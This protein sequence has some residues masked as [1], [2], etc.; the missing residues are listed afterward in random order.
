MVKNIA[1]AIIG[2]FLISASYN[3]A[4]ANT[5]DETY[6][7]LTNISIENLKKNLETMTF[8]NLYL[9][10]IFDNRLI[11]K[12]IDECCYLDFM[13]GFN[14]YVFPKKISKMCR[15]KN[16]S[17]SDYFEAMYQRKEFEIGEDMRNALL[18]LAYKACPK[19]K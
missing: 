1:A 10:G 6:K 3:L 12:D 8:M 18:K 15:I 5:V 14:N 13:N 16:K 11:N 4:Q 2:A 17:F 7:H 9:Q 19:T